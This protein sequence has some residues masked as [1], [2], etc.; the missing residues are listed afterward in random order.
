MAGGLIIGLI[1][2][3]LVVAGLLLVMFAAFIVGARADT[4]DEHSD[5]T[6][7][8]PYY[9]G[10]FGYHDHGAAQTKDGASKGKGG[11]SRAVPDRDGL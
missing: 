8:R 7:P 1:I 11:I 2:A 6:P 10:R 5:Y 3:A 4:P 9:P